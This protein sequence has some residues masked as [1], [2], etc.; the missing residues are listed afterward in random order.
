MG[1]SVQKNASLSCDALIVPESSQKGND[2]L[3]NKG[4]RKSAGYAWKADTVPTLRYITFNYS[5]FSFI[6]ASQLRTLGC[7]S[8]PVSYITKVSGEKKCALVT[9]LSAVHCVTLNSGCLCRRVLN[10]DGARRRKLAKMSSCLKR[11]PKDDD[12][13]KTLVTLTTRDDKTQNFEGIKCVAESIG[14]V[15]LDLPM[16]VLT[17]LSR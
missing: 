8:T 14:Q 9:T 16:I 2:F 6:V 12:F 4:T 13:Q 5:W 3:K 11:S 10:M 17:L 15:R 1:L 7:N